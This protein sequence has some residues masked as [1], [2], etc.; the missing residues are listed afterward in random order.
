M[1][2][3]GAFQIGRSALTAY[4]AALSVTG[5]NIANLANPTYAR[6]SG[7]LVAVHG[8][9]SY[10]YVRPGAGV[11]MNQLT[12]HVDA[13]LESRL[14]LSLGSRC[15]AE[16]IYQALSQ[17]EASYNELTDQDISTQ[18][19][20]LFARFSEL[21]TAPQSS[22]ARGL[23]LATADTLIA[24]IKRQRAGLVN[25]IAD[26][27]DSAAAA[28]QRAGDLTAE[29]ASLNVLISQQE[30]D[31]VTIAGALR[32]RR[33][34]LLRDLGELMDI[35]VREQPSGSINVYVGSEPLVEFDR[36]RGPVVETVLENGVEIAS[37]R[38][39]DTH[40]TVVM[41][42][43][44]LFG[45]LEVRDRYLQDQID[46]FDT[47]AAGLIYEVNR[48]HSSGVGLVGYE[49][50][51]SEY[52]VNDPAAALNST[53]AALP[54][55]LENG[56]FIVHLRDTATGQEITRQ[57][58]V[59]LDGLNGDD[60]TLN[61]LAADLNGVPGL[62]ATITAD[63]RLQ[64]E[65]ADGQEMW[66]SE[67][68]SGALAALGL[69]SFFT[70]QD[71]RD[72]DI[73][74]ELR[75]DPRLIATSLSGALN[76]GSNAGLIANLALSTST[77]ALLGQRSIQDY[78]EA[79]I[80]DLAVEASAALVDHEAAQAVYEGLYAQRE[81]ISGVNLDEEAVNLVQYETAYQGAARY[82]SV[83]DSLTDEI[84]ALL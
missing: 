49:E 82:L 34:A 1:S 9:P 67:D 47:L 51:L 63:N 24:S 57:I 78:H 74:D 62:T 23:T 36:S 56:T 76:D 41:S 5:Q 50:L 72:I 29:I 10:G 38:F 6:Q 30:A 12:R 71:A 46:R 15:A 14:R 61:S 27:N 8:G 77:S 33:D 11:R 39:S 16:V 75:A 25:Q 2:L 40:G 70:G 3:G 18:L 68:S 79:L 84:M 55:P 22:S 35:Q 81:A 66:F 4:Q 31:G 53:A 73:R 26:M 21:G 42:D 80:A 17:T 52:S 28:A 64:L 20:E 65:A 48:L 13:A 59:D 69:A 7:R 32:D 45:L 54:F 83:V 19:S 60:T 43:G 37:V 44:K 58:H